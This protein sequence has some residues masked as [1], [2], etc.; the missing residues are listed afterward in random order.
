[1]KALSNQT[2]AGVQSLMG[3]GFLGVLA[4]IAIIFGS[5]TGTAMND[6]SGSLAVQA[7]GVKIR[8]PISAGLGTVLVFFLVLWIHGGDTASKFQNVLLFTAYWI[9]PFIAV[10]LID[11]YGRGQTVT[12]A[13][14]LETLDFRRLGSGWP[15]L[16]ALVVGFAA[17]VPFMN[18]GIIEGPAAAAL[19]GADISFYVGFIVAAGVYLPLRNL[20]TRRARSGPSQL[21]RAGTGS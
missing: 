11:W 14:L 10:V 20:E 3:G 9:A 16:V 19:A 18:T 8:R 21:A 4:L 2:A 15:A 7:G 13:R 5:V 6:Y 1:A 17:M 12:R